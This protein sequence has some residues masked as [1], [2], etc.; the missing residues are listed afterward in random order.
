MNL[1]NYQWQLSRS[2]QEI[3]EVVQTLEPGETG[4]SSAFLRL[5]AARGIDSLEELQAATQESPQLFHDPFAMYQMQEA[6]ERIQIAIANQEQILI[7]GDYDAD[8]ITSTLVLLEALESLGAQVNYYI[9]NRLEDGYGPNQEKYRQ[10]IQEWEIDLIITV[11]N[12]V[13]GHEAID[14]ANSQQ[15]DVIVTDHH[16]LPQELPDAYAIIH[17]A[18]PQGNYPF[19]DLAGVAVAYKLATALLEELP[20]ESLELVA[21]GTVADMVHLK[22]ENR[23]LVVQGLQMMPDTLRIGL[24]LLLEENKVNLNALDA[25]TIGFTIAPHLNSLGRLGDANPA[26]E[27]LR[28]HDEERARELVELLIDTNLKRRQLVDD[29]HQEV[30]AHIESQP[31]IPP[32]IICASSRWS[33]GVLGIV[34]SRLKDRFHRPVILFEHLV[35]EGIFKGSGRSIEAINL[36]EWLQSHEHLLQAFG[37]HDQAAGLT[38]SQTD[39]QTFKENL[40]RDSAQFTAD[41]ESLPILK[42]DLKLSINEVSLAFIEEVNRLGPFGMSNPKPLFEFEDVTLSNI[43]AIGAN[44]DHVKMELTDDGH[45]LDG[46]G[47]SMQE[48]CQYLQANDQISLVGALSINEWNNQK[49]SQLLLED[50]GQEGSQWI[51]KRSTH[52]DQ[53]LFQLTETLYVFTH[54]NIRQHFAQ[55]L[56]ESSQSVLYSEVSDDLKHRYSQLVLVEPPAKIS[57]AED[58][59]TKDQWQKVYLAVYTQEPKYLEG[60]LSREDFAVLYRWLA[61][62]TGPIQ[63]Q[64]QLPAISEHLKIPISKLR[65]MLRAFHEAKFVTIEGGVIRFQK[66]P[67]FVKDFQEMPSLVNYREA[68]K[69]EEILVYRTLQDVIAYFAV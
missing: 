69:A 2:P 11:D 41:I 35:D 63:L 55:Q 5:A 61:G 66:N 7:Y 21:I 15:V 50:V 25:D 64:N 27:L 9:P 59:L 57:L 18:H 36:Y 68:M 32:V 30:L 42:V 28:T 53:S 44:R 34:A 14:Y 33:V 54:E 40:E 29:I 58:L 19:K 37:G 1:A 38:V 67:N 13:A 48:Q 39:W 20:M 56:S 3:D 23:T 47:F 8:G 31:E 17:P 62:Q 45:R 52:I 51:D 46:V 65:V 16:E 6:V 4:F 22:D 10:F 43:R 24:Q 12:G 60:A 49:N 26:V